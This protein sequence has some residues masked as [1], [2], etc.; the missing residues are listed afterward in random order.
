MNCCLTANNARLWVLTVVRSMCI[1]K[2]DN[3]VFCVKSIK[4]GMQINNAILRI[5]RVGGI[6]KNELMTSL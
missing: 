3:C 2:L 4:F 1:E 5:L 6:S